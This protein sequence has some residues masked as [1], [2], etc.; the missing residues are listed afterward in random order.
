[1]IVDTQLTLVNYIALVSSLAE[2]FFSNRGVYQPHIGEM[3]A[4]RVFYNT[5]V[6][7]YNVGDDTE[8]MLVGLIDS[9]PVFSDEKVIEAFNACISNVVAGKIDFANAYKQALD[10]VAYRRTSLG[11]IFDLVLDFLNK[12]SENIKPLLTEDNIVLFQNLL[13]GVQDR[14]I[15]A[16]AIVEAFGKSSMFK[17]ILNRQNNIQMTESEPELEPDSAE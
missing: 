6:K 13:Q 2:P 11:H 16:E 1:M 7:D 14:D 9:E 4:L 8:H 10:I 17:E 5:C 15:N 3:N 12:A